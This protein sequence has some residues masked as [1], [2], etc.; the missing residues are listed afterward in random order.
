MRIAFAGFLASAALVL[1]A[2]TAAAQT[3]TVPP[4]P[5]TG[6]SGT[7]ATTAPAGDGGATTAGAEG[8]RSGSLAATGIAADTLVPA[9]FAL[10]GA[11]ALMQAAARRPRRALGLL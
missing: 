9:G 2:G 6:G 1:G 4:I 8:D 7:T 11:G 10:I 5:V 3:T